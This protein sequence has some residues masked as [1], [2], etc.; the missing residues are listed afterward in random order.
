MRAM[1]LHDIR[2]AVK[3]SV[4][5]SIYDAKFNLGRA[6]VHGQISEQQYETVNRELSNADTLATIAINNAESKEEIDEVV[7]ELEQY[8]QNVINRNNLPCRF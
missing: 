3:C 6:W 1:D 4:T 5:K 2:F 7:A 8:L